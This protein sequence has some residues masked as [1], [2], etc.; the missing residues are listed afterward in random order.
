MISFFALEHS[1]S[2]RVG[3]SSAVAVVICFSGVMSRLRPLDQERCGAVR[4]SVLRALPFLADRQVALL[5]SMP[6]RR[7]DFYATEP[8][9]AL[10]GSENT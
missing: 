7:P 6:G 4:C 5:L 8:R 3:C 9:V 1:H 10:L 2:A